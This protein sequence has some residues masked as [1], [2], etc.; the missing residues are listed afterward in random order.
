[1]VVLDNGKIRI[2]IAELGAEIRRVTVDGEERF[3]NGD[4]KYWT[5]VAPVLFPICGGLKDKKY[6]VNGK[7]YFLEN[8]GFA[9]KM[10][11]EKESADEN[12]AVFLLRDTEE[13]LKVYPWHFELRVKYTL[14]EKNIRVEYDVKNLSDS[15]MYA[16][17]GSHEA[18]LC[19]EGIEDY[20]IIFSENETLN[21]GV[22]DGCLLTRDTVTY[23]SNS[24]V[25][26]IYSKYFDVDT[27]V[28]TDIKSRFVTLKNRKTEKKVSVE[29]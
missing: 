19:P 10:I 1:M 13:T 28:F 21:S 12:T 18:Y 15:T 16:A 2:E 27:L 6:T 9:R 5:G 29:F 17:V 20:D 8:H 3:W 14:D 25:L 26:P 11:F 7:E 22:L 4:E 23:L 24:K